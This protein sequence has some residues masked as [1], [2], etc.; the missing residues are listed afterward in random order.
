[1]TTVLPLTATETPN[2][3]AEVE[4]PKAVNFCSCDHDVPFRTKTYAAPAYWPFPVAS[5]YAPAAM[6]SPGIE[7]ELPSRVLYPPSEAVSFCSSDHAKPVRLNTYR[8]PASMPP[9]I[10]L[11]FEPITMESP[12]IETALPKKSS[13]PPS[14][15]VSFCCC[16]HT[17]PL[18]VKTYAEPTD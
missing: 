7:T 3:A 10:S 8:A 4:P 9:G 1:M 14:V 11:A 15:A 17:V 13:S 6:V 18:R 12:L 2:W 16:V 5:P